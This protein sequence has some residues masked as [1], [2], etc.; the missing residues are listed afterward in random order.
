M[1]RTYIIKKNQ[2]RTLT[3]TQSGDY[4]VKLVGEG[5]EAKV[6]AAFNLKNQDKLNLNVTIIHEAPNTTAHTI[7]KA[8]ANDQAQA[9]INGHI[10]IKTNAQ[11]TDSH[12]IQKILLLSDQAQAHAIPNLEIEANHVKCSHAATIST[13]DENQLFYLQSRGLNLNQAQTLIARGFLKT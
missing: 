3:L 1:T 12:L 13:I 8:V 2:S 11:L 5:A 6:Q 4:T 9:H 10:L 7:L